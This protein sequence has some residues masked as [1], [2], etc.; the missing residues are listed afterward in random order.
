MFRRVDQKEER[1][2]FWHCFIKTRSVARLK[3]LAN[4]VAI[5]VNYFSQNDHIQ[6]CKRMF[7]KIIYCM[8]KTLVHGSMAEIPY[9]GFPRLNLIALC[10]IILSLITK[11][12]DSQSPIH[13]NI[14]RT[15][16][17]HRGIKV[18]KRSGEREFEKRAS[19]SERKSQ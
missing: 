2:T 5:R 13:Y 18:N 11:Q 10:R 6:I 15:D 7:G 16:I 4:E 12:R 19:T 1:S 9:R 17:N 3:D 14:L 8:G